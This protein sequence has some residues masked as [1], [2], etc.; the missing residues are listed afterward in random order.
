L[1]G[2]VGKDAVIKDVTFDNITFSA[3]NYQRTTLFG[4]MVS[5]ATLQNIT[6][7]I[8]SYAVSMDKSTGAPYVEQG[9][10]G[11]RYFLNN[12]VE[13]VTFNVEG[14]EVYRLMSRVC[15]GNTFVNVKIYAD[16]Y[17]TIGDSSDQWA[18][19]NEL[20]VGVEFISTKTSN[21]R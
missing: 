20:P 10:F 11:A 9:L 13:N 17:Q 18:V 4:H 8:V 2:Q 12:V 15:N 7:N 19:I 3:A 6:V 14:F 21:E 1:F 16:G 5:K